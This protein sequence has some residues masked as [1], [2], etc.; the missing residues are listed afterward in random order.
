M[1][2]RPETR[3]DHAAI[4]NVIEN[5]FGHALE[6]QLVDELRA[7]GDAVIALVAE[8]AAGEITGHILLS[9]LERPEHC[10]ALA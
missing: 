1:N 2:I 8:N 7:S 10:L 6:A 3:A 9:K 4:R 5:A